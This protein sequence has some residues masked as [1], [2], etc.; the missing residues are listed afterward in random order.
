M[1][2]HLCIKVITLMAFQF[3]IFFIPLFAQKKGAG[4]KK[5]TEVKF[6]DMVLKKKE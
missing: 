5:T 2:R 1:T 3:S 4:A 6:G